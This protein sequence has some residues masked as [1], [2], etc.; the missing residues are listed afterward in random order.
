VK[1]Y[2]KEQA[3]RES[4]Q[5]GKSQHQLGLTIDFG[6]ITDEFAYTPEGKWLREN[7]WK[8][9][10]SLSYP[11]DMEW[12]TGYRHECWHFRYITPLG[13]KMEKEFFN[14]IQ[15]YMLQYWKDY[16]TYFKEKLKISSAE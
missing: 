5:P 11:E 4:A 7:S 14:G 6:S 8:Y 16:Q 12:L 3:D 13:T 15:Q 10:F 2:G 9:G 1:A